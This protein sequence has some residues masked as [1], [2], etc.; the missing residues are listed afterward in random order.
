MVTVAEAFKIIQSVEMKPQIEEVDILLSVGRVLAEVIHADRDF[1]PFNRVSMDGIAIHADTFKNKDQ[2][3]PIE[4]IQAAGSL[5]LILKDMNHCMEVMTGSVLPKNTNAV[6]RYEDLEIEGRKAK[7][8][9]DRVEAGANIHP[10]GKDAEKGDALLKHGQKISA[11]EVALFASVGKK[12]VR[13]FSFP[14][15][16]V[17]SSGDELVE[18]DETPLPHQI[19]K[20]NTYA[21]QAAMRAMSWKSESFHLT[22]NKE[23]VKKNLRTILESDDVLI[24]SGGVSKGKFDFIPEALEELGI[25]K[26]FH[27]VSQRPGKPFWFGASADRTKIVF[28]LPGNPV[29]TFLCFHKYVKPWMLAC[30]GKESKPLTARLTTDVNF[31]PPLTYFLQVRAEIKDGEC[32]AHPL[33]GGGSGD[34]ANLKDVDGFLELPLEKSNFKAGESYPYIAFRS[35]V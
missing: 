7:I 5:Q 2:V 3:F 28:A 12:S 16:A 27:Q 22:D 34:F 17:I 33:A 30:F 13:V 31:S 23:L 8:I 20:S 26:L 4:D 18:V 21:L 11:A 14:R 9:I 19:R 1:P 29:S 15:T 6:V 35:I 10:Q 32:L 25:Q 24:L